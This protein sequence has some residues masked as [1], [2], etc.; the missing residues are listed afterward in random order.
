M[1]E[2]SL[3]TFG[4][5]RELFDYNP[6]TG[7]VTW[8]ISVRYNAARHFL[9]FRHGGQCSFSDIGEVVNEFI[10]AIRRYCFSREKNPTA[11]AGR[12]IV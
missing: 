6:W 2:K 10:V 4:R 11:R 9:A 1:I 5:I 12:E 7:N 3:P 8:R